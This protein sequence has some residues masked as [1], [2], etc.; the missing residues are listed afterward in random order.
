MANAKIMLLKKKSRLLLFLW[1]VFSRPLGYARANN[2]EYKLIQL[3]QPGNIVY[4]NPN[5]Y[6]GDCRDSPTFRDEANQPC[7]Y[8]VGKDCRRA[9]SG[10]SSAPSATEVLEE[11]VFPKF[12]G[13]GV[14]QLL[15]NCPRACG[16]GPTGNCRS[17]QCL[18]RCRVHP[19]PFHSITRSGQGAVHAL[20]NY[21]PS[22]PDM[23]SNGENCVHS[24]RCKSGFCDPVSRQCRKSSLE[25]GFSWR[26]AEGDASDRGV[27]MTAIHKAAG[28]ASAQGYFGR[29]VLLFVSLIVI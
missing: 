8:W 11:G 29:K 24:H 16:L 4:E 2:D 28:A 19:G 26:T 7:S 13:F 14:A 15:C 9:T 27:Q 25:A 12:S 5:T 20:P 10:T 22:A 18:R 21:C 3:Q 6:N 1:R 23:S 17:R